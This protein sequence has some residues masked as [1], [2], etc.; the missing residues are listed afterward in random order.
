MRNRVLCVA[1]VGLL[2]L[3]VAA[4]A[5]S[6]WRPRLR[7][8]IHYANQRQGI[9]R[10]AVIGPGGKLYRH[11]AYRTAPAASVIKVMFM[12]A[13]L[14]RASV[15]DRPLNENDRGLLRPMIV[16]SDNDAATTIA[17]TLGSGPINRLARVARMRNFS[18]TRPWGLSRTSSRD[19]ARFMFRLERYIPRRHE[20]YARYLLSHIVRSQR[21]G[22]ARVDL[23]DWRLF[24]KSGWGSG[25]GRVDH[26]VAF[27]ERGPSRISVAVLTEYSPSH[28]YGKRTLKGVMAR[29]LRRLPENS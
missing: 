9:V 21:W 8:A 17:N 12:V 20:R 4:P 28:R 6:A 10:F 1:V 3:V 24:F 25:T 13:Y 22:I 11:L 5:A 18:Y 23:D 2:I 19:Q 26:Q 27:I 14:R 7:A 15:R 29:L 16:R